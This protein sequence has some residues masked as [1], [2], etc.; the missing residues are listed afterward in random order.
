VVLDQRQVVEDPAEGEGRRRQRAPQ[1]LGV[2]PL[3]LPEHGG[4]REVEECGQLLQLRAAGP[5]LG[6]LVC[7]HAR[8]PARSTDGE[9]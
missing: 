9:H 6:A 4:P 3:G 2:E 8:S 7:G 5:R 1:L